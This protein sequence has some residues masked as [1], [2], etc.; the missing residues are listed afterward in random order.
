MTRSANRS[1]NA[2][3]TFP[4][5]SFL[6]W[7]VLLLCVCVAG[8]LAACDSGPTPEERQAALAARAEAQAQEQMVNYNNAVAGKR[9][10]M[11][12]NFADYILR[13]FPQ[14]RVAAQIKPQADA[15]RAQVAAERE[16]RRLTDLWAYHSVDDK[17]AKGLVRT[18]YIYSKDAIGTNADGSEKRAR[19]VL[20]RHPQWGDDVY[21]LAE[22][23]FVCAG[24]CSVRLQFDGAAA[25]DVPAYL[26]ETGEPAIFVE[27]FK[28]V[29]AG[30]P[31][32]TSLTI[33]VVLQDGG[34]K[35]LTF[36]VSEYKAAT[37]GDP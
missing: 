30:L 17:E 20:R 13:N 23:G 16:T 11:A 15:L 8:A 6:R 36:E 29:A 12:L 35:T 5:T 31:D 19:L 24:K 26:P 3:P 9:P 21:L 10:D 27:D 14:T 32:A 34:A 22:G 4:R 25:R 7:R 33:D 1:A 37:I 2:I 28:R 18:A